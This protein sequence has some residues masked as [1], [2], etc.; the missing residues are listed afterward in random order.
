M[1]IMT[2]IT[3]L[4]CFRGIQVSASIADLTGHPYSTKLL[5]GLL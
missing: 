2:I 1:V 3:N 5:H 4:A